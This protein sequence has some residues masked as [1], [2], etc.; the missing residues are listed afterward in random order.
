MTLRFELQPASLQRLE[1]VIAERAEEAADDLAERSAR[2]AARLFEE[3]YPDVL[4]TQNLE[5]KPGHKEGTVYKGTGAD[6]DIVKLEDAMVGRATKTANGWVATFEMRDDL[7]ELSKAKVR[8]VFMK[9][10]SQPH[11]ITPNK[12]DWLTGW[13]DPKTGRQARTKLV[14]HPGS[15][16]KFGTLTLLRDRVYQRI[17]RGSV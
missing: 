2:L 8:T 17:R 15:R 10:R 11:T 4:K 7:D 1:R 9:G 14:K 3:G 6:R 13:I 12:A 5:A 16:G